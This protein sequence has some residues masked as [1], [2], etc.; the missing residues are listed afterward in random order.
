VGDGDDKRLI[1]PLYEYN[2]VGKSVDH[3]ASKVAR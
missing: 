1:L 3:R 2:D